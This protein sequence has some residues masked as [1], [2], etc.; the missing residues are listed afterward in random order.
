MAGLDPP[1]GPRLGPP[2]LT[3]LRKTCMPGSS[4]VKSGHDGER[5]ALKEPHESCSVRSSKAECSRGHRPPRAA[6]RLVRPASPPAALAG[7][8]GG[9][10]RSVSGLAIGD[11]PATDDR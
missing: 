9:A 3:G 10:A 8:A 11:H 7:V 2:S 1:A 5:V 4:L 6:A